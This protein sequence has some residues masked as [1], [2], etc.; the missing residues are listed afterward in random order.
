MFEP[1]LKLFAKFRR[2]LPWNSAGKMQDG[3]AAPRETTRRLLQ[4]VAQNSDPHQQR[5]QRIDAPPE[6]KNRMRT[7]A[8]DTNDALPVPRSHPPRRA[9]RSYDSPLRIARIGKLAPRDDPAHPGFRC[10]HIGTNTS[11][12]MRAFESC[13]PAFPFPFLWDVSAELRPYRGMFRGVKTW[14]QV[15]CVDDD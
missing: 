9:D 14:L 12:V 5:L 11:F 2:R 15:I 6:F 1:P 4:R 3:I 13:R 7:Q 8:V 10:K